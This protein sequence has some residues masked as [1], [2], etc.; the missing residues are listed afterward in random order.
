M[1]LLKR[2]RKR[3]FENIFDFYLSEEV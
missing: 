2:F 3:F 1:V